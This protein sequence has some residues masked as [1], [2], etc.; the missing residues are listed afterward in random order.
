[1]PSF[2]V[3][4]KSM[5]IN[6]I[7]NFISYYIKQMARPIEDVRDTND[8]K[9]LWK[10]AVRIRDL[11]FVKSVSN[12]EHLKMVLV[13]AKC[14]MTQVIIQSH[15]ILKHKPTFI[16]GNTYIM[17]NFKVSNNDFSFKETTY[18]FKLL[19]Y[20][21]TFAKVIDFPDN[22]LKFLKLISL[23]SII[24]GRFQS[25]FLVGIIGGVTEIIHIQMNAENHKYKV[26]FAITDMSWDILT[27]QLYNYYN[28]NKDLD[29]VIVLL[30]NARV[31]I[32]KFLWKAEILS[33][34]EINN[35]QNISETTNAIV[36]ILENFEVGQ[37]ECYYDGCSEF[38]RSAALKYEKLKCFTNHETDKPIPRYK[39]E[40]LGMDGKFRARFV[41][42]DNDCVKLM[43]KFSLELKRELI[44]ISEPSLQDE[45]SNY[46]PT[47]ENSAWTL[48][49]GG[50]IEIIQIQMNVKNHKYKVVFAINDMSKSLVQCTIWGILT[51]QLY[52]YYN[53]NKDLD[54][55]IVLL[56]NARVK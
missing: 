37:S 35:L 41:F 15:L 4:E 23:T 36:A 25:D 7:K 32:D 20:G 50:V 28:N 30:Q 1:M 10:I 6:H 51:S 12:K 46:D 24:A 56:Q 48:L 33:L 44:E 18:S 22:S 3:V 49:I 2:I 21:T 47:G 11:W 17:H 16:V 27:S 42:W 19:F 53:S 34:A 26:V 40:V 5:F 14:D 8:F 52:N 43:G 45:L 38:T 29:N 31:N 39:L 9:D 13:D 54:N 55:V